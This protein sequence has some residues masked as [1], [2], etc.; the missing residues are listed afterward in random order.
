MQDFLP[1][2]KLAFTNSQMLSSV[3][4]VN[5]EY[6]TN[7]FVDCRSK[8]NFFRNRTTKLIVAILLYVYLFDPNSS[9]SIIIACKV[10]YVKI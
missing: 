5:S 3:C 8:R 6:V 10:I 7:Y 4:D 1:D 9:L 2:F